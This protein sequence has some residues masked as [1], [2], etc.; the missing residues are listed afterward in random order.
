MTSRAPHTLHSLLCMA[1][2]VMAITV[3]AQPAA[4]QPPVYIN[5]TSCVSGTCFPGGFL[6]TINVNCGAGQTLGG[7]LAQIAD[8]DGP[9][10]I[11][12]S[13]TCT[14]GTNINGFNRLTIQGPATFDF[15]GNQSLSFYGS[16]TINLSRLTLTHGN[17]LTLQDS[18]LT[19]TGVAVQ[20]S[21]GNG[22]SVAGGSNL[23]LNGDVSANFITDSA[24]DGIAVRSGSMLDVSGSLTLSGSGSGGIFMRSGTTRLSPGDSGLIDITNNAGGGISGDDFSILNVNSSAPGT[25]SIH[26]NGGP[27]IALFGGGLD[28]DGN[29]LINGNL[30]IPPGDFPF[31]IGEVMLIG[32]GGALGGGAQITPGGSFPAIAVSGKGGLFLGG[33]T[34]SGT[35]GITLEDGSALR[36][37]GSNTISA[38]TCDATSWTSGALGTVGSNNCG[39][40]APLGMIGATGPTGPAGAPGTT[41]PAGV[42]GATG[43]TGTPGPT[44]ATGTTGA[45]GPAGPTG[46]AGA[47]G[48]AGP[49]GATGATGVATTESWNSFVGGRLTATVLGGV[50]T[51]D[52]NITVKRV[53]AAAQ[54]PPA[55]CTTQAQLI[56]TDGTAPHTATLMLSSIVA[57]SGPL[58]IDYAAGAPI[59]LL[60]VPPTGCTTVPANVNVVVQYRSR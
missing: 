40:G 58:T 8:R 17:G 31:S 21:L 19:L 42:T 27:G 33:A 56:V 29:I 25:V 52:S 16:R 45:T 1:I 50:L 14:A 3:I 30:T 49:T 7:A 15:P 41:G 35:G 10:L 60:T 9:N 38:L 44:G 51:P 23:L 26:G 13:G 46:A 5:Q 53:Q 34:V 11:N 24:G 55:G 4:A 18:S 57:D 22:I 43:A 59:Y 32:G 47:A 37:F 36:S 54:V 6:Q 48:V 2:L 20:S 28:A 12:V 39:D